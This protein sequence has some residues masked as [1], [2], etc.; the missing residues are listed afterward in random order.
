MVDAMVELSWCSV[1]ALLMP[2]LMLCV[3]PVNN[4]VFAEMP[5]PSHSM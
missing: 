3:D 5:L 4:N 2:Q 1:I